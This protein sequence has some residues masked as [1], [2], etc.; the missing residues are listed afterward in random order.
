MLSLQ[1]LT[2][3]GLES[4]LSRHSGEEFQA[5][6]EDA[7]GCGKAWAWASDCSAPHCKVRGGL[8]STDL[9]CQEPVRASGKEGPVPLCGPRRKTEGP[10]EKGTLLARR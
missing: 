9:F 1:A 6:F 7:A 2:G 3:T 10:T 5:F 8:R 4:L